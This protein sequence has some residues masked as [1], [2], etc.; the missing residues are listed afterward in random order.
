MLTALS[1]DTFKNVCSDQNIDLH[2]QLTP[3]KEQDFFTCAPN[4]VFS[5]IAQAANLLR[6]QPD[7]IL[8]TQPIGELPNLRP[9]VDF[10]RHLINSSTDRTDAG[11]PA[12]PSF[13]S[14]GARAI[15]VCG[16]AE[17]GF[18]AA[19]THMR[20][21]RPPLHDRDTP[22]Q[23]F[24]KNGEPIALRKGIR[25]GVTSSLL[26]APVIIDRITY[27]AGSI[28]RLDTIF[29]AKKLRVPDPTALKYEQPVIDRPQRIS[30]DLIARMAFMRLSAYAL[31]E[32]LSP[33]EQSKNGFTRFLE[34]YAYAESSNLSD[35]HI[36]HTMAEIAKN[37]LEDLPPVQ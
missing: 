28:V 6:S 18:A 27:P 21:F 33:R 15:D 36:I 16:D 19:M 13:C 14:L 26:L 11:I 34:H 5:A 10:L 37:R 32:Y 17:N 31:P 9:E 2:P 12:H 7:S 25:L 22:Y 23:V 8:A 35:G 30:T 29:D 20:D 1:F 4:S 24:E 3:P